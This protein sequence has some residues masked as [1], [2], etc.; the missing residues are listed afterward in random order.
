MPD[1]ETVSSLIEALLAR[2]EGRLLNAGGN[3]N[4]RGERL[5]AEIRDEAR[6][7]I[8]RRIASGRTAAAD[9]AG[10]ERHAPG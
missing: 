2:A 3:P 4:S 7:W 1:A 9:G 5:L 8:E 10:E 6:D